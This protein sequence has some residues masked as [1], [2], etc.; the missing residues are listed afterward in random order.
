MY[1]SDGL[2]NDIVAYKMYGHSD[3]LVEQTRQYWRVADVIIGHLYGMDFQC[4]RIDTSSGSCASG[5]NGRHHAFWHPFTFSE[6]P[7]DGADEQRVHPRRWARS[8]HP[9]ET[10]LPPTYLY[11][12]HHIGTGAQWH[13]VSSMRLTLIT[14]SQD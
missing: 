7:D 14:G 1:S 3:E 8:Y 13:G 9:R 10:M 4:A 5:S 12:H 2:F 6:R 11:L